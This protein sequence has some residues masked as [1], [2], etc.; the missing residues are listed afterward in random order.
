[1][2]SL[3][4][5]SNMSENIIRN[6]SNIVVIDDQHS[7][8]RV[9]QHIIMKS[10]PE[11]HVHPFTHVSDAIA[12]LKKN[13]ASLIITDIYFPEGSGYDILDFVRNQPLFNDT[14]I[15]FMTGEDSRKHIVNSVGRGISDYI[16]KPFDKA[17]LISKVQVAIAKFF[18]P[19]EKEQ[20]YRSAEQLITQNKDEEALT[21]LQ[22][23]FS[24]NQSA[25]VATAI[26]YIFQKQRRIKDALKYVNHSIDLNPLYHPAYSLAS[27][28][29]I[30]LG[31]LDEAIRTIN[32]EL[33]INS[34]NIE[35]RL[36]LSQ[37]YFDTSQYEK[38]FEQMRIAT[39]EH[40]MDS[41]ILIQYGEL[42][43][44][45]KEYKKASHYYL[46]ARRCNP[47]G[48]VPLEKILELYSREGQ[49]QKAI[50]IFTDLLKKNSHQDEIY[51][52]RS[53]AYELE[54]SHKNALEDLE[55]INSKSE[56][57]YLRSLKKKLLLFNKMTLY[58]ETVDVAMQIYGMQ[59]SS[60]NMVL[61]G[62]CY[63]RIK[64]YNNAIAWIEKGL[65]E[66]NRPENYFHLGECYE[67]VGNKGKAIT[68]YKKSIE[69]KPDYGKPITA[70]KKI[71]ST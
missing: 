56:E 48:V 46:K 63:M 42:Y 71:T 60:E 61:I 64:D 40:P 6:S 44:K 54:G 45:L 26:A 65:P 21:I 62:L 57:I 13:Q 3:G 12:W 39:I 66:Q 43:E 23:D 5:G 25:R 68:Y 52:L 51:L 29:H 17:Q 4:V 55:K 10:L 30:S 19:N 34:K 47:Q 9:I 2:V 69:L 37:L 27:D 38:A 70:L 11:F 8:L 35:K 58:K 49:T 67:R 41:H 53:R 24:Q 50:N 59:A 14:P 7:I 28:I 22:K 15:I 32:K 36:Q 31:N 20:L 33:H 16:L 18:Q 1:M